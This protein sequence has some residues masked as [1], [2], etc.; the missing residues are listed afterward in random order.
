M[1][2]R[3]AELGK[4][5]LIINIENDDVVEAENSRQIQKCIMGESVLVG[6]EGSDHMLTDRE[7]SEKVANLIDNWIKTTFG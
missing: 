6:I 1:R 3:L 2:S 7:S 5:V 4:P